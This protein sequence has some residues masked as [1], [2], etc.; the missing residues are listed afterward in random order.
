MTQK[1]IFRLRTFLQPPETNVNSF[2]HAWITRGSY[3]GFEA[4][5][6]SPYLD[7]TLEIADCYRRVELHFDISDFMDSASLDAVS[8]KA[9]KARFVL[10]A[11]FDALEAELASN[12]PSEA[13]PESTNS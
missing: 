6:E 8:E 9:Y 2:I 4:E 12:T 7:A 3:K 13:L 5:A 1:D 11:F 10:N